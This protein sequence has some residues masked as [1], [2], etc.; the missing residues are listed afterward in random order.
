[1]FFFTS[2]CLKENVSKLPMTTISDCIISD[3]KAILKSQFIA[4]FLNIDCFL[5]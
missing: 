4:D 5:D 1:M 3:Y 2:K